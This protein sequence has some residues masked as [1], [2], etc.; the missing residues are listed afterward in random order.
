MNRLL[1]VSFWRWRW[2][3]IL[4]FNALIE[5]I[6]AYWIR[7]NRCEHHHLSSELLQWPPPGPLLL[8]LSSVVH[9]LQGHCRVGTPQS[10]SLI[11]SLFL[12][13]LSYCF[14]SLSDAVALAFCYA[15]ACQTPHCLGVLH[16]L[17][18][19]PGE[20]YS[21]NHK[22]TLCIRSCG[23]D[24]CSKASVWVNIFKTS[25]CPHLMLLIIFILSVNTYC[26]CCSWSLY[27]LIDVCN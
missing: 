2:Y 12:Y 15:W 11:M 8:P 6:G 26:Y 22:N 23:S 25:K 24:L 4:G 9:S 10:T 1:T 14:S 17:L 16:Q 21:D 3:C 27:V 20:A 5:A 13:Y 19:L 7:L 18:P